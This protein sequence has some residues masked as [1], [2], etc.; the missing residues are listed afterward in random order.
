MRI[1]GEDLSHKKTGPK[2]DNSKA[3]KAPAAEAD[4]TVLEPANGEAETNVPGEELDSEAKDA[5][6]EDVGADAVVPA[7]A[8]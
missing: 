5:D 4:A 8:S 3:S 6:D 2:K 7:S 1:F